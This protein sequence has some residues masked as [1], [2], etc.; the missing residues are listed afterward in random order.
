MNIKTTGDITWYQDKGYSCVAHRAKSS[1]T[2]DYEYITYI[3][4][5]VLS[6]ITNY[7]NFF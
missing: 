3:E 4:N 6:R 5:K 7:V 2:Y 1:V